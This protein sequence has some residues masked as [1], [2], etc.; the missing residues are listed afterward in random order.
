MGI[1]LPTV[2]EHELLKSRI[3]LFI[4]DEVNENNAQTGFSFFSQ[5]IP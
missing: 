4:N 1:N 3:T 2:L 5:D